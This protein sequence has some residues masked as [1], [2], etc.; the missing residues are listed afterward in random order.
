MSPGIGFRFFQA[1]RETIRLLFIVKWE[2]IA[3]IRRSGASIQACATISCAAMTKGPPWFSA[4]GTK[5]PV[6]RLKNDR[7]CCYGI[8]IEV[9]ASVYLASAVP[10]APFSALFN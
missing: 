7:V 8:G 1:H 3:C 6:R 10:M 9:I 5:R 2:V 4:H